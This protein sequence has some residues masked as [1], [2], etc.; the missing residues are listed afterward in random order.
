MKATLSRLLA[1]LALSYRVAGF[2]T[3]IFVAA[4]HLISPSRYGPGVIG[5]WIFEMG[6]LAFGAPLV[7]LVLVFLDIALRGSTDQRRLG[8]AVSLLPAAAMALVTLAYPE[9]LYVAAWLLIVGL[10]Y[11]LAMR[12]PPVT[13]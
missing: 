7:L 8:V 12:V 5:T 6:V 3:L 9:A 4:A 11:G 1:N 13:A 10:V 2:V